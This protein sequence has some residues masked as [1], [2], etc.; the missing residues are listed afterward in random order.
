MFEGYVE[1]ALPEERRKAFAL[2]CVLSLIGEQGQKLMEGKSW[3]AERIVERAKV[4]EVYLAG[5]TEK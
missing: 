1:R 4:F 5:K 3:G 2:D